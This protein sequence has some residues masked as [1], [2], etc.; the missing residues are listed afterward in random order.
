[1]SIEKSAHSHDPKLHQQPCALLGT[2][3]HGAIQRAVT[4]QCC[5]PNMSF[6]NTV[7]ALR[8][9]SGTAQAPAMAWQFC[10]T[11]WHSTVLIDSYSVPKRCFAPLMY[12]AANKKP[13]TWF[14]RALCP[15]PEPS[16]LPIC[17]NPQPSAVRRRYSWGLYTMQHK[18]LC[19]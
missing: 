11:A 8:K 16:P 1:M 17:E 12:C 10:Q 13:T 7:T 15:G 4:L 2:D 19:S 3:M 9:M 6:T 14:L 18:A 5:Q